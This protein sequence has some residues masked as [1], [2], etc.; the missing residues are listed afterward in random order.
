MPKK[1]WIPPRMRRA[2]GAE[3]AV[4]LERAGLATYTPAADAGPMPNKRLSEVLDD[5]VAKDPTVV[6]VFTDFNAV[7]AELPEVADAIAADCTFRQM[8]TAAHF[9]QVV[10]P[11][12]RAKAKA[13]LASKSE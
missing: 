1:S 10:L 6:E 9:E 8:Q 12:V 5:L 7:R 4:L 3:A 13:V 11:R 2:T